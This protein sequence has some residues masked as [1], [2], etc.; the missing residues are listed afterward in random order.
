MDIGERIR[1]VRK[2]RGMTQQ[3]LADAAGF[4]PG[5]NGRVRIQQYEAGVRVPKEDILE[6]ISAALNVN[7]LYLS[8]KPR[9]EL[10]D[11]V[12]MLFEYDYYNDILINKEANGHFT[13]DLQNEAMLSD[14]FNEWMQKKSDL[15]EG[16][17]SKDDYIEWKINYPTK[18]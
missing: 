9:T 11:N 16:K 2:F 10:L 4:P 8:T 13:L 3:E 12:F 14:L 6:K 1:F 7:S 17:I 15:R 18:K 5:H